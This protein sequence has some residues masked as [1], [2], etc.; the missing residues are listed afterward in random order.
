VSAIAEFDGIAEQCG[1]LRQGA[2]VELLI[3]QDLEVYHQ[4]RSVIEDASTDEIHSQMG[5]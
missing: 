2:E 1:R 5:F 4:V 3:G